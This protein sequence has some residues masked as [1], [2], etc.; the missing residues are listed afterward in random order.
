[1]QTKKKIVLCVLK[2][3][4]SLSLILSLFMMGVSAQPF[5]SPSSQQVEMEMESVDVLKLPY[6]EVYGQEKG[7][8]AMR[9]SS[10]AGCAYACDVD[11]D[12]YPG[13]DNCH[14]D[15]DNSSSCVYCFTAYIRADG[16]YDIYQ[17]GELIVEAALDVTI[18][19]NPAYGSQGITWIGGTYVGD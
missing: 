3:S 17:K 13:N 9:S 18:S 14:L 2:I 1:M 11:C 10:S 12:G 7:C 5:Q 16:R 15:C 6:K 19:G 4:L 8:N